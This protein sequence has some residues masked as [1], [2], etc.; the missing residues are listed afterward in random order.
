MHAVAQAIVH[1]GKIVVGATTGDVTLLV[2]NGTQFETLFSENAREQ[3]GAPNRFPA[4]TG[5][6]ATQAVQTGR[7]VF[8][9]SFNEWQEHYWR[10]ASI[11]AD[12]GFVSSATLP[13]MSLP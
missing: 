6:C 1:Q 2:E 8:I 9:G 10:S 4:E 13:L 7:G 12:G 11:A 3:D 5:Y